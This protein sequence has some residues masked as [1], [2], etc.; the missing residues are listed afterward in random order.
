MTEMLTKEKREEGASHICHI[1]LFKATSALHRFLL[2]Y[3]Y[4]YSLVQTSGVGGRYFFLE[5]YMHTLSLHYSNSERL[6]IT[7]IV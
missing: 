5:K 6:F 7:Q 2:F 1:S 3:I 4:S